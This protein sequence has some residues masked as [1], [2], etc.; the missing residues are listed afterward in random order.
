MLGRQVVSRGSQ[1]QP[2]AGGASYASNRSDGRLAAT[3]RVGAQ[4]RAV[5]PRAAC[6]L[7]LTEPAR[8]ANLGKESRGKLVLF[9]G[10]R[11]MLA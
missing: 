9:W 6:Q 1:F 2:K 3:V 7:S 8:A 10:H 11:Q 5:E 4:D